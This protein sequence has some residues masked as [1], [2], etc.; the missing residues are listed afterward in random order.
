MLIFYK[1]WQYSDEQI[2]LT[3]SFRL[4]PLLKSQTEKQNVWKKGTMFVS[5]CWYA[6]FQ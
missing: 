6:H 4:N 2:V 1:T 5:Y 3:A